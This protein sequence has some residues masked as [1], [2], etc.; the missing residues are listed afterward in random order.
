ML[1]KYPCCTYNEV[2]NIKRGI[3]FI[4]ILCECLLFAL[5]LAAAMAKATVSVRVWTAPV[6]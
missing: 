5:A 4:M 1:A 2:I 3:I 6:V